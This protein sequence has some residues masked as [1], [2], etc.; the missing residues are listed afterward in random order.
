MATKVSNVSFRIDSDLKAQ[1]DALF[2]QLG[3]NMTT[4]FNIFLRQSVREGCIPFEITLNTPNSETVAALIEAQQLMNNPDTKK[5]D[6]ED[7]LKEL[8]E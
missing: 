1:A 8:K 5:Y 3:M 4:A 2:S 6:I 7:A